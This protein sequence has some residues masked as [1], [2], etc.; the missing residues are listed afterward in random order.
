MFSRTPRAH[1]V[2]AA[3]AAMALACFA[4]SAPTAGTDDSK[5]PTQVAV[6]VT[7]VDTRAP[8]ASA[9]PDDSGARDDVRTV[10][11]VSSVS[12]SENTSEPLGNGT[13]IPECDRYLVALARCTN[14]VPAMAD[15][16][17]QVREAYRNV[18]ASA[19]KAAADGC[20]TATDAVKNACN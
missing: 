17:K 15:T 18:P 5:A 9:R 16:L 3:E 14:K 2:R 4:C 12:S 6:E 19:R 10:R 20:A 7:S 13:G 8:T 1:L 11:T